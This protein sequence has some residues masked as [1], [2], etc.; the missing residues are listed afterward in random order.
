MVSYIKH[1]GPAPAPLYVHNISREN[2]NRIALSITWDSM[3]T[4]TYAVNSY[5][6]RAS[7]GPCQPELCIPSSTNYICDG[8]QLKTHYNF[9]VQ[10]INCKYQNSNDSSFLL[11]YLD[12]MSWAIVC[13]YYIDCSN[14]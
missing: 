9:T 14:H 6:V 4:A 13:V 5:C 1:T 2:G 11:I 12:G 10:A 8:L 3:F 7:E